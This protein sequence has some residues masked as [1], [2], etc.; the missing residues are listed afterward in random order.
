MAIQ[1]PINHLLLL[2]A[3]FSRNWGGWLAAE[4]D[5]YLLGHSAID[6]TVRD[7]LWHHRRRGGFEGALAQLQNDDPKGERLGRLQ[8]ALIQMFV[9]MDRAFEGVNFNFNHNLKESVSFFLT[10]FD[11]IFTLNQDLLLERHYLRTDDVALKSEGKWNQY[12]LPGLKKSIA[13]AEAWGGVGV[14]EPDETAFSIEAG[15]QPYFK[16]H[17]S[18]N[19][20]VSG[21]DQLLVMGGNKS[22]TI[23]KYAVLQ[24]YH[25]EF[26]A[27]LSK[28]NTK[29]MIIGYSFGDDHINRSITDAIQAGGLRTFIIDPLGTDVFDKNRNAMIY[30]PDKLAIDLWPSLIGASRRSLREV[31]GTDRVEYEKIMRF[32]V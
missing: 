10:R 2:G 12:R 20:H 23:S 13:E 7:V 24:K 29:L 19:W 15:T 21:S 22:G 3:G 4:A 1:M 11:A 9:D 27:R 16:L 17:G 8:E 32:F 25:S 31:F 5:E 6:K 14:W 26:I 30:S 28:E 18:A